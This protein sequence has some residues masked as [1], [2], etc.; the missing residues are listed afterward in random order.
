MK[1][2]LINPPRFNGNP[3]IR[4]MRCA[5]LSIASIYPP[6]ELAYLAGYLRK[7]AE[8]K[9]MDANALNQDF[10]D[11]KAKITHF[12]PEA[13]IFTLCKY[14]ENTPSGQDRCTRSSA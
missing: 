1:I 14:P 2:L 3:M 8:V 7:Y 6:I 11:V 5:G 12:R 10:D 4:E 9:I 13:V